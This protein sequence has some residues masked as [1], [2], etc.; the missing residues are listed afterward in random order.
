VIFVLREQVVAVEKD[1]PD[2]KSHRYQ[3]ELILDKIDKAFHLCWL[4][5]QHKA[6]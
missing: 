1:H 5:F 6:I 2:H 3:E 4:N